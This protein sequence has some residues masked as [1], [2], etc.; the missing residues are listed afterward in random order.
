MRRRRLEKRYGGSDVLTYTIEFDED[1]AVVLREILER[2]VPQN[3]RERSVLRRLLDG[4]F[5][6]RR[7]EYAHTVKR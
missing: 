5:G 7:R 3:G 1:D 2:A 4:S 6:R